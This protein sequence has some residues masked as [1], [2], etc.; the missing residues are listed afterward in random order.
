[1]YEMEKALVTHSSTLAWKLPWTEEPGGLQSM[2]SLRVGHDWATSLSCI[3]EGNGNPLQ[4]SWRIPGTGEPGE[5]PS[6]GSHRVR[7]DWRD[8]AAVAIACMK[9]HLFVL[10]ICT[11]L[12]TNNVEHLFMC[13]LTICIS[14]VID[15]SPSNLDSS[16]CFIQPG[17]SHDV[18]CI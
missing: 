4:C 11:S 15:I 7:H 8:L 9:W 1:M 2:G 12:I 5:L 18:L 13:L 3:G 10:L 14:E 16:L 17:I 6:M